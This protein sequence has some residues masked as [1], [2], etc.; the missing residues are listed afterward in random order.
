MEKEWRDTDIHEVTSREGKKGMASI[1]MFFFDFR[2][3]ANATAVKAD[4]CLKRV[5]KVNKSVTNKRTRLYNR[6]VASYHKAKTGRA[7]MA[8]ELEVAQVAAARVP[9]LEE[10]LRIVRAQCAD[11]QE[12]AKAL[13]AKEKETEGELARLRRLEANHLAELDSVKRVKQTKVDDLN[14]QLG[15]VD[16]QCRKLREE[17]TTQS[18]LLTATAKRWVD[19]ISVLR[20]GG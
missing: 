4:N 1:E 8:R 18:Q 20:L 13:A 10:D 5:E 7:E 9:Q 15:E 12:A 11:I 2:A 3:F 14:Q 16:G 6:L 17:I 19:E